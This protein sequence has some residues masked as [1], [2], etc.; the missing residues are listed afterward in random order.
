MYRVTDGFNNVQKNEFLLLIEKEEDILILRF[1]CNFKAF[2]KV[3]RHALKYPEHAIPIDGLSEL[4]YADKHF[5]IYIEGSTYTV[6]SFDGL[7]NRRRE[8]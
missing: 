5:D 7:I 1:K 3:V 4:I 8:N 6:N 2:R